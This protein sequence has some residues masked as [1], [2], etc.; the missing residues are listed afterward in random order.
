MSKKG[1]KISGIKSIIGLF[2]WFMILFRNSPRTGMF[3]SFL[4]LTS[5]GIY[6]VIKKVTNRDKDEVINKNVVKKSINNKNVIN[7]VPELNS[8]EYNS[9]PDYQKR[10]ESLKY[11]YESGFM[12]KE[13]YDERRKK[14]NA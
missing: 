8:V 9:S 5:V 12:D 14:I 11:L 10:L 1:A 7:E 2:F 4:V 3:L 6:V 13:E